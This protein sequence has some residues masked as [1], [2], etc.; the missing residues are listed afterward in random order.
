[1]GRIDPFITVV[2][3]F[4]P[5]ALPLT[6][7]ITRRTMLRITGRHAC[8]PLTRMGITVRMLILDRITMLRELPYLLGSK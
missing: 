1:M 8:I 7:R 6:A 2:R 5:A 3:V 4:T